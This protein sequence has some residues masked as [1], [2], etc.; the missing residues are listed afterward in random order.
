LDWSLSKTIFG[1]FT[2]PLFPL[3]YSTVAGWVSSLYWQTKMLQRDGNDGA[4]ESWE[5]QKRFPH[6]PTAP[7]KSC[8]TGPDFH[9]PVPRLLFRKQKR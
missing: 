1:W 9:I 8:P 2:L 3:L 5:K 6:L 7:W 4:V